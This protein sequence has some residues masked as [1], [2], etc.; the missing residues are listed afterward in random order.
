MQ[1]GISKSL[2]SLILKAIAVTL[3]FV[4]IAGSLPSSAASS[5]EVEVKTKKQ[6][7]AQIAGTAASTIVFSTQKTLKFTI[8]ASESSSNKKLIVNAPNVTLTNKAT[9]KGVTL[10]ETLAFTEKGKG[11]SLTVKAE[12][13]QITVAKGSEV[14][15]MTIEGTGAKITVAKGSEVEK[16][17]V[18]A[19]KIDIDVLGKAKVGDLVCKLKG[20]EVNLNVEKKAEVNVTLSKKTILTVTG[21]KSADVDIVSKA[22]NSTVTASVPVEVTAEKNLKLKLKEGAEGSVVDSKSE[23]VNVKVSG[24]AADEVTE[25]V[26][27]ETVKEPEKKEEKAEEKKEEAKKEEKK[28]DTTQTSSSSDQTPSGGSGEYHPVILP[29]SYSVTLETSGEGIK[30]AEL[31]IGSNKITSG[32]NVQPGTVV[33]LVLRMIKEMYPKVTNNGVSWYYNSDS[34]DTIAEYVEYAYRFTIDSVT[35]IKVESTEPTIEFNSPEHGTVYMTK[36]GDSTRLASG[37]KVDTNSGY[38]IY[39]IPEDGYVPRIKIEGLYKQIDLD[40]SYTVG[41][42]LIKRQGIVTAEVEFVSTETKANITI[43]TPQNA[44]ITVKNKKTGNL[45]SDGEAV[46]VGEILSVSVIPDKDYAV[47]M[48]WVSIENAS[49]TGYGSDTRE[50]LVTN[51]TKISAEIGK[52]LVS[53]S[54]SWLGDRSV[55]SYLLS[56]KDRNY[57]SEYG[58]MSI[59]L[60]ADAESFKVTFDYPGA[61]IVSFT[62]NDEDKISF[63]TVDELYRYIY[64]QILTG[65]EKEINIQAILG[66]D[67]TT[68]VKAKLDAVDNAVAQLSYTLS[69]NE[70]TIEEGK[71][72]YVPEGTEIT[73]KVAP[74][75]GYEVSSVKA[76]DATV[77]AA[78]SGEYKY[79][80][81]ADTTFTITTA[82]KQKHVILSATSIRPAT[83]AAFTVSGGAI[84]ATG[85]AFDL[86]VGDTKYATVFV[87]NDPVTTG[88]AISLE[89]LVTDQM[90]KV[91]VLD[92]SEFNSSNTG[93]A[94]FTSY[95][96]DEILKNFTQVATVYYPAGVSAIPQGFDGN[97]T[98]SAKPNS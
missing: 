87:P 10:N 62:V 82:Q 56:S 64:E 68:Y 48:I 77:T 19:D 46:N 7:L 15:K 54:T 39:A 74:D 98:F 85:T 88:A 21:D 42:F 30:S 73:V 28:E 37:S 5:K 32:T 78:T 81:S 6:L 3:A 40:W 80:V 84:A 44:V 34:R 58:G 97:Q 24:K 27:G 86:K 22:K 17:N 66:K 36:G 91:D 43:L 61:Q 47:N 8:P 11:N 50:V 16:M 94:L 79:T 49:R 1:K 71:E 55:G 14:K 59:Y 70:I 60:S 63:L 41:D 26:A 90:A 95:V 96:L 72:G 76:G 23:D 83:T 35:V 57:S 45:I 92:F 67:T 38:K 9:F 4:T 69:G 29:T 75:D 65:N 20:A 33:Q 31:Y 89:G 93:D 52:C 2:R 18:A 12:N 53:I 51:D 25:K 13:A